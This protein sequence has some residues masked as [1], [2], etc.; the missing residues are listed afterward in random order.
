MPNYDSVAWFYDRLSRLVFGRALINAQAYLLHA[1]PANANIL[2]A[3]G[4]TGWILDEITMLHPSGLTITYIDASAGMI[5]LSRKRNVGNN[6]VIFIT[7]QVEDTQLDDNFDIVLTPFLFD[8]F[9][10]ETVASVF[11]RLNKLLVQH[12]KWLYCDFQNTGIYWQRALLKI[13]YTFFRTCTGIKA[14]QL[15]DLETY[16]SRYKYKV[17]QQKTFFKNFVVAKI[18]EKGK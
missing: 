17:T 15:P 14:K 8:N 12:G 13:M 4:G 1:I 11:T 7:A 10:K 9:T 6:K 3:G 2:I 5:A 16:F 18:Y